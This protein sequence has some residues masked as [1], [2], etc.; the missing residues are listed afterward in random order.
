M[1]PVQTQL[2]TTLDGKK[3]KV[4]IRR[5]VCIG[6]G[7]CH[8]LAPETFDLDEEGLVIF[9][10]QNGKNTLDD[11]MAGAQSCP[12]FAIEIFDENDVKLWPLE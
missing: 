9:S 7:S 4:I 3:I 1:D 2:F 12:V 5:D 10:A 8:A 11:I 6:A